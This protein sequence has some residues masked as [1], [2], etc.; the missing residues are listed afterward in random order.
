MT[1]SPVTPFD[2]SASCFVSLNTVTFTLLNCPRC[3][4]FSSSQQQS[5][6]CRA[7]SPTDPS[8]ARWTRPGTRL[9]VRCCPVGPAAGSRETAGGPLRSTG[10][11]RTVCLS[12]ERPHQTRKVAGLSMSCNAKSC[13][14]DQI[15]I[16]LVSDDKLSEVGCSKDDQGFLRL[17]KNRIFL[18]GL[19]RNAQICL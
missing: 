8:A 11:Q 17:S 14:N 4:S 12:R 10:P 7:R 15:F 1:E 3:C 9:A 18:M 16:G 13:L 2:L 19:V 6:P 5:A